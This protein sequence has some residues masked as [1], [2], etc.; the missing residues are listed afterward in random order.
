M[1]SYNAIFQVTVSLF[2]LVLAGIC[3]ALP[4][5]E[6]R[7]TSTKSE[8]SEAWMEH[9][10]KTRACHSSR[11]ERL[12]FL[13]SST[14]FDAEPECV[15]AD[16]LCDG[17]TDCP[18]GED[19]AQFLCSLR[20][21]TKSANGYWNA[22]YNFEQQKCWLIFAMSRQQKTFPA[23]KAIAIYYSSWKTSRANQNI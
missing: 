23:E 16:Q 9:L 17:A 2:I 15:F 4:P 12:S 7:S 20:A 14:K 18:R 1:P 11:P 13:C 19:E 5:F 21:M 8:N 10:R 3:L 22:Q 6:I